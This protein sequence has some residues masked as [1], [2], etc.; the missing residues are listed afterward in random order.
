[1][2]KYAPKV[3]IKVSVPANFCM[4]PDGEQCQFLYPTMT[5]FR[6]RAFPMN[7][8][9]NYLYKDKEHRTHKSHECL[10]SADT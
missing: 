6:C 7:G 4:E 8:V 3:K 2:C 1:M 9:G 5:N 10:H